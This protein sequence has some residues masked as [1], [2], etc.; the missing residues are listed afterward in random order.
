[1][2]T[3]AFRVAGEYATRRAVTLRAGFD[4]CTA[5]APDQSVTPILP[6]APRRGYSAGATVPA[7][8]GGTI[9][10]AYQFI[11][12]QDRRGRSTDGGLALPTPAVNNGVY[13]LRAN[14]VGVSLTFRF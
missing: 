14:V 3:Y 8:G 7:F 5:A 2:N 11:S 1:V 12:Q 10:V 6:D 9:N 4:A 13:H